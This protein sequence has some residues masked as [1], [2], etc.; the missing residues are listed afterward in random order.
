VNDEEALQHG[1]YEDQAT[2]EKEAVKLV[3]EFENVEDME[4]SG[5]SLGTTCQ[6]GTDDAGARRRGRV[7]DTLDEVKAAFRAAGGT[8]P[9]D[10][11]YDSRERVVAPMTTDSGKD[12]HAVAS[13]ILTAWGD[14]SWSG[15]GRFR[16]R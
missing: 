14:K 16:P 11:R 15:K 7:A 6:L 10:R 13:L 9:F 1:P 3:A 2:A 12:D 4:D 8:A 5:A